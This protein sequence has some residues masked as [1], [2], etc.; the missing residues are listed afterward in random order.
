MIYKDNIPAI[1]KEQALWCVWKF[2]EHRS[3][4]PYNAR[5]GCMAKSGD[6]ETFTNFQTAYAFYERGNYDGL[7]IGIF[8]GFCAI[9]IDHCI[10]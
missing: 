7:G 8:D 9:D 5:T 1:M 4:L 6:K 2:D 10:K 3:K